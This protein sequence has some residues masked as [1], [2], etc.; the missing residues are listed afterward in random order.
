MRYWAAVLIVLIV[1]PLCG[2]ARGGATGGVTIPD[3]LARFFVTFAGPI[4]DTSYYFIAIDTDDDFGG[5]GPLPVAAGPFWGNGWGTGSM[6]HFIAYHQGRYD[7]FEANREV[8]LEAA[9][10][11]ITAAVGSPVETDTGDYD[12]TTTTVNL[13]AAT[14]TGT[15]PVTAVA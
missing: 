4:D 5:D 13:G 15:G 11:G 7:V 3:L 9:T 8:E 2:C 1:V 14:P 12:L 6:T 10:G